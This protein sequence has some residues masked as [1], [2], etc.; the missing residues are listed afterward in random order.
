MPR[1]IIYMLSWRCKCAPAVNAKLPPASRRLWPNFL[2]STHHPFLLQSSSLPGGEWQQ[3][4]TL[5]T[6]RCHYSFTGATCPVEEPSSKALN[7][8][9]HPPFP[10]FP[11]GSFLFV[12]WRWK[13][14]SQLLWGCEVW[15][16]SF[17]FQG[18]EWETGCTLT[19]NRN[20]LSFGARP[21]KH[22]YHSF[23]I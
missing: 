11:E 1:C 19:E 12:I 14:S 23:F 5:T 8:S 17:I 9:I 21:G 16:C 7:S 18:E 3:E 4:M 13:T 10:N 15:N 2:I 20:K 6:V 22:S